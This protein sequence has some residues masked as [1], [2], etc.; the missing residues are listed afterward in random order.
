MKSPRSHS[1]GV[2]RGVGGGYVAGE[3]EQERQRVLG[4]GDRVAGRGVDD[5]D[6]GRRGGGDVDVV[7]ADAGPADD[8]EAPP[9]G[10][11][12]GVGLDA[13]ADEQRVVLGQRGQEL[14]AGE[15]DA[16]VDVV[17]PLAGARRPRGASF[18][19]TRT[20]IVR[21]SAGTAR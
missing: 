13:A 18:S 2:H 15:A 10:D 19:A 1:P 9:G 16:D 11:G 21:R 8:D 6:A 20:R 17:R 14:L 12:L 4:G 3:R 5:D 7:D